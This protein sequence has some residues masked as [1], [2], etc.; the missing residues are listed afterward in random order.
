MTVY[1]I[2][3]GY[4][5]ETPVFIGIYDSEEKAKN[6]IAA[7][8]EESPPGKDSEYFYEEHYVL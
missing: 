5:Y 7:L 2:F 4:D 3:L 8:E 6:Q 1:L